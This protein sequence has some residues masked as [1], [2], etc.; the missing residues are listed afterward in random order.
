MGAGRWLGFGTRLAQLLPL[1]AVVL[2]VRWLSP[3]PRDLGTW[4]TVAVL[5]G[6]VAVYAFATMV[7]ELGHV[8]AIWLAGRR[9]T[10]F[11]C[12]GRLIG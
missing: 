1:L 3:V 7:H 10:A 2:A 9:P 8:V 12:S 6:V 11:T 4:E 5:A